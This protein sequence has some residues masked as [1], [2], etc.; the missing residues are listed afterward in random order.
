[1]NYRLLKLCQKPFEELHRIILQKYID[2]TK[3]VVRESFN[4]TKSRSYNFHHTIPEEWK[5]RLLD[6]CYGKMRSVRKI[7]SNRL[8]KKLS[9]LIKDSDW[10]KDA[11]PNFVVNLSDKPLNDGAKCALGFGLSFAATKQKIDFVDVAKGFCNL[12]KFGDVP[13]QDLN[14]CKGIVYNSLSAPCLPNCPKRFLTAYKELRKDK[15]LHITKADKSNCVVIL[16]H[17]DYVAKMNN[18]L[19]DDVTYTKLQKNPLESVNSEFN[20]K[21]KKLLHGQEHL[22][23]QFS[24]LSPSLPY[25]YGLIK[26]HK[27]GNPIRPIICS[28]G[29]TSY[30]LS[31]WLVSILSPLV[32]TISTSHLK[33]NV[34]LINK[35]NALHI[36]FDFKLVSYDV[37]SLFTRVPVYDLLLFL[38]DELTHHDLPL[39]VHTIIDMIKLCVVDAKFVCNG[40]YFSQ[41]F[42]MAMGNPLSPLLSNL[43]ME[44]FEK[45]VL[46]RILPPN[47]IWFRYVDDIL[48]IWPK[49]L[50]VDHFLLQLNGLV[51]S[52]KFTK[53]L[54]QD[55]RL[56]FLDVVIHRVDRYFKFDV[57]RKPTNVLSYVHFYSAHNLKT[58]LSVFSSMFLRAFRICSPEFLDEEFNRIYD[59]SSKLKYPNHLIENAL[60]LARK[61]FYKESQGTQFCKKNLLVLPFH[62]NL[63]RL[64]HLLSSFNINVV[65]KNSNIKSLLIKNSPNNDGGCVYSIPCKHCDKW[66]IGQTGKDLNT[67]INQHK[68]SVRSGQT[69]SGVFVHTRDFGHNIDW[70][71]TKKIVS[72]N[73]FVERNLVESCFIKHTFVNNLNLSMGLYKLDNFIVKEIVKQ[74][75]S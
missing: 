17:V 73:S 8:N 34:D 53:E 66:Y 2:I 54:E 65:F 16:N 7:V 49:N 45:E 62:L 12:E 61:S 18:L 46:P 38:E 4:V 44:F 71:N 42:G 15:D 37:T 60:R 27:P 35:L 56:P 67:R 10:Q 75:M 19:S 47:V 11:N 43:Y 64:P 55:G 25:M 39:P 52:I 6:Y 1:M 21:L 58:K 9:Q 28:T 59:I 31:K 72:C 69:S 26:T 5:T 48:C 68:Y 24:S 74:H 57:F 33:N 3:I 51:P 14:I 29:S 22:I 50:D 41:K 36:N 20:R 32:G 40:E 13:T 70:N 23:K 30:K 63:T